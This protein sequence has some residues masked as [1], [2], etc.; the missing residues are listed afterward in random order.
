MVWG[1][2]VN[3]ISRPAIWVLVLTLL[4]GAGGAYPPDLFAQREQIRKV[5]KEVKPEIPPLA[6]KWKISRTVRVA[7][8]I[9]QNG[10]VVSAH[11]LGGPP[12]LIP[13]AEAAARKWEFEPAT[14][15]TTQVLEFVF[16]PA[17][18]Q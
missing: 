10:K 1:P 3:Y 18:S 8:V 5:K 11:A 13:V 15:E 16:V 6:V 14:E 9:G 4:A 2:I 12:L 17:G 7:V